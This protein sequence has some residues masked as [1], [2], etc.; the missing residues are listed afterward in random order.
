MSCFYE[1]AEKANLSELRGRTSQ[2]T[3]LKLRVGRVYNNISQ[4]DVRKLSAGMP[5]RCEAMFRGDGERC[6]YCMSEGLSDT[7]IN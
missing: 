6:L 7:I 4:D 5:R 1:C 3:A 2:M